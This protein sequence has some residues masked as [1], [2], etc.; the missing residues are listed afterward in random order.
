MVKMLQPLTERYKDELLAVLSCF[1][2]IVITG[3]EVSKKMDTNKPTPR[4]DVMAMG[5]A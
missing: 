1:D 5:D 2:W 3:T 4:A